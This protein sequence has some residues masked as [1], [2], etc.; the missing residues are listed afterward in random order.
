MKPAAQG[1]HVAWPASWVMVP[2]LQLVQDVCPVSELVDVPASQSLQVK[3]PFAAVKRPA[4]AGE[5]DVM[6]PRGSTGRATHRTRR[7]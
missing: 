6:Q 5:R 1:W 7:R 2:A 3:D 4:A